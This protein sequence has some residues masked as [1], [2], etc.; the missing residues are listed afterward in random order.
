V[1]KR[2]VVA[3]P[4]GAAVKMN[5][6]QVDRLIGQLSPLRVEK[7]IERQST[8]RPSGSQIAIDIEAADSTARPVRVHLLVM[9][10]GQQQP[11]VGEYK[12]LWFE[13]PYGLIDDLR[14]LGALPK[15]PQPQMPNMP[16]SSFE[17]PQ[18]F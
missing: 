17:P 9:D 11:V 13:M 7:Y 14:R 8:T 16:P 2:W 12:G 18:G 6:Q 1:Q 4:S 10:P 15:A 3:D 5:D